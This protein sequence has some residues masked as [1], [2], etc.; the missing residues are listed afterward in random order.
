[1]LPVLPLLLFLSQANPAAALPPGID[2]ARAKR[3]F[4]T[5]CAGCHGPEGRG[6]KGPSLAVPKLRHARTDE[7]LGQIILLGLPGTEMPPSWYLGVEGV[8][9]AVVYV[10][11]LG[12]N[13]TPPQV[14]GDVVKGKGLFHGKGG[15]AGCHTIGAEGHA[16]GP[17]LSDIGARRSAAG[18]REALLDPNAA[19]GEGFVPVLAVTR[20]GEKVSG[21]RVNED[22]FTIQIL[23]PSG[24][25]HSL[26]KSALAELHESPNESKMPSYK[27]IFSEGE[28][29]DLVAYLS[30]L[31]GGQ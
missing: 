30:S 14:A 15:C 17:D 12:A 1:M 3:V 13:A 24:V 27:T 5:S 28:L 29:Q 9:L 4:D 21:I 2:L 26:R 6:G 11:M 20:Q 18:L 8:T 25:V 10:R 31:R 19:A 23:E 7:E 22:N 16:F